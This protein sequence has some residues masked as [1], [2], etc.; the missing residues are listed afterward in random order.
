MSQ[1]WI[2]VSLF[3]SIGVVAAAL[4]FGAGSTALAQ[5]DEKLPT[6]SDIMLKGHKGAEAYLAKIGAAAKGGNWNE[7]QTHAKGLAYFGETIIKLDPPKGDKKSWEEQAKLYEK[8]TKAVY[9][10]TQDKDA[11][12]TQVA[13][14]V[15]QKSCAG[16]HKPHK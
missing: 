5:K 1:K 12:A 11:K 9:K 14:G 4:S 2:R 3:A 7:A 16:C 10:A 13:L 8:N 6:I 15:V